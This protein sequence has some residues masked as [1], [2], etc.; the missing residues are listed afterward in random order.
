MWSL[1]YTSRTVAKFSLPGM[2]FDNLKTLQKWPSFSNG[3]IP[4]VDFDVEW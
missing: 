4:P 2:E 3:D 1:P